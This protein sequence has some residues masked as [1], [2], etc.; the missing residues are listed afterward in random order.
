[1]FVRRYLSD[2][3][4][5]MP[6]FKCSCRQVSDSDV[7]RS[8]APQGKVTNNVTPS[9]AN[10]AAAAATEGILTLDDSA[11]AVALSFLDLQDVLSITHVC[12]H[13]LRVTHS[14][15]GD[16]LL[17]SSLLKTYCPPLHELFGTANRQYD[18]IMAK[19]MSYVLVKNVQNR[20][21]FLA[22]K[23][24]NKNA[25]VAERIVS[26]DHIHR[27]L[28]RRHLEIGASSYS[29][30]LCTKRMELHRFGTVKMFSDEDI[31][32]I[33][34]PHPMIDSLGRVETL[35]REPASN[36]SR[37]AIL[38]EFQ[39]RPSVITPHER[40]LSILGQPQHERTSSVPGRPLL[41]FKMLSSD[42]QWKTSLDHHVEFRPTAMYEKDI[43]HNEE[44]LAALNALLLE[45]ITTNNRSLPIN[46]A[47]SKVNI[48]TGSQKLLYRDGTCVW[49]PSRSLGSST[50]NVVIEP[51]PIVYESP[52]GFIPAGLQTLEWRAAE[53]E[54]PRRIVRVDTTILCLPLIRFS[55]DVSSLPSTVP[56]LR[57]GNVLFD[58]MLL[59]A[60]DVIASPVN[61]TFSVAIIKMLS[62]R[63]DP[64]LTP[65]SPAVCENELQKFLEA[66]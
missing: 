25:I 21:R 45:R 8:P 5:T 65:L 42:L 66:A 10:S 34:A 33:P 20:R 38:V 6:L 19:R 49:R 37:Y 56:V 59:C 32:F 51:I 62:D 47:V 36:I 57:L 1:M 11:L 4:E 40:P 61:A 29:R 44:A 27:D 35:Y 26:L 23:K 63:N 41:S 43:S 7:I 14:A 18:E 24:R 16:R 54:P 2:T 50:V 48:D 58:T 55:Y 30:L 12:R 3:L 53:I 17:W 31:E 64:P 39:L 15:A 46:I 52:A 60:R 22:K 28:L 13:F 9:P